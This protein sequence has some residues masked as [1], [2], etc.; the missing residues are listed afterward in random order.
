MQCRVMRCRFGR[1][2]V[3]ARASMRSDLCALEP[4]GVPCRSGGRGETETRARPRA[5][6]RYRTVLW[7]YLWRF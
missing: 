3:G 5:R 7:R 2:R 4:S 6:Y 1:V